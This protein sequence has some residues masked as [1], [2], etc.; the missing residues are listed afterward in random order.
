MIDFQGRLSPCCQF[1]AYSNF[2]D[3]QSMISSCIAEYDN[4]IMPEACKQC[5]TDESRNI[6]SLRQGADQWFKNTD[7]TAGIISLDI[8]INNNCNLACT[9]CNS[10]ASTL[11][12]KLKNKNSF[13]SLTTEQMNQVN[14]IT[15][16]LEMVS[17]QGGEPFYGDDFINWVDSLPN[18]NKISLEIFTNVISVDIKKIKKWS[19]QFKHIKINAS[20]DGTGEV[21]NQIRW[22]TNWKKFE[23]KIEKI[24]TI[25][26]VNINFFFTVQSINITNMLDF[27]QWRNLKV[28]TA[29]IIFSLANYP[30]ELSL[31]SITEEEKITALKQLENL[32]CYA[33]NVE[34]GRISSIVN[35]IKTIVCDDVLIEKRKK[36]LSYTDQ[37]RNNYLLR[38]NG[39]PL[40]TQDWT[41]VSDP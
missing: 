21:Y 11:W 36:R 31:Y 15:E 22:P 4:G 32:N 26:N 41:P 5:W 18:K 16:N 28:S 14:S 19:E 40:A 33:S 23:N 6:E 20:V 10:H 24:K 3:Y 38:N 7:P 27:I 25:N 39:D 8:R 17:I 1:E 29:P 12:G 34:K 9:M 35:L 37:L 13:L 30:H 2:D